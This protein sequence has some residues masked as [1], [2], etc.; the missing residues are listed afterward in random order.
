M[1]KIQAKELHSGSPAAHLVGGGHFHFGVLGR[2]RW[3]SE[4]GPE[5]R[6][7]LEGTGSVELPKAS[8]SY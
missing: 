7:K 3:G 5:T 4:V 6:S 2:G 8:F 1:P